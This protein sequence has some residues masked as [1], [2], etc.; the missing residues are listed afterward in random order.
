MGVD[1]DVT[2]YTTAGWAHGVR[3]TGTKAAYWESPAKWLDRTQDYQAAGTRNGRAAMAVLR[4]PLLWWDARAVR[5]V[6]VHIANSSFTRDLLRS[7]YGIEA[8]VILCPH[9]FTA[10]GSQDAMPSVGVAGYLLCVCRLLPVQERRR[11]CGRDATCHPSGYSLAGEW[12][13]RRIV[14]RAYAS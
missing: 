9:G 14:G 11:G 1:A 13:V 3:A 10:E 7:I 5:S 6:D 2:I 12:Q 8:T 4:R